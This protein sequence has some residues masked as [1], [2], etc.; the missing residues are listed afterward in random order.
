[1]YN[2]QDVEDGKFPFT[3]VHTILRMHTK[4]KWLVNCILLFTVVCTCDAHNV[5]I[6]YYP[7]WGSLRLT[8]IISK[9]YIIYYGIHIHAL[10]D[11]CS[12]IIHF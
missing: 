6:N 10:H 11:Q 8:L 9:C 1:M 7:V 3:V 12:C 2:Q 5:N 4:L